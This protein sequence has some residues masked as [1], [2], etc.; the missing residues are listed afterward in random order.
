M[1]AERVGLRRRRT[2]IVLYFSLR[3]G[4][5]G[6]GCNVFVEEDSGESGKVNKC[7]SSTYDSHHGRTCSRRN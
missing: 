7:G 5:W 4:N 1:L 3:R 6:K 2:D